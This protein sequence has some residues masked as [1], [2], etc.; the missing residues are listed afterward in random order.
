MYR[1][2]RDSF[3]GNSVYHI[4]G[5]KFF[6]QPE[7]LESYVVDEKYLG[8]GPE[9][10]PIATESSK[11]GDGEDRYSEKNEDIE[12][13][14]DDS[15]SGIEKEDLIIVD[16]DGEDDPE[17]PQNWPTYQKV[18]FASLV[19]F[20]TFSVYVA[21]AIYTPGLEEI[22]S[23][24]NVSETVAIVPLTMFVV[25][26]GIGPMFLSPITE[27]AAVG[28]NYV[29]IL[30]LFIF[31]ILQIPTALSKN[32]AS[33]SVL[34][35]IS[36]FFASPAL[37]TGGA[38][39][40]DVI[41]FPYLPVGL[42]AW[43]LGAV[44]GP[45]FGPLIG[46]VLTVKH[47][48]RWTFW[49]MA[50]LSG[51][52]L[53]IL[54]FFLPESYGKALLYRKALRLR[55]L[56]G[57]PKI[58]SEGELEIKSMNRNQLIGDILWRPFEITLIEPVVMLIN[59]YI[60]LVYSVMYLWFE[61]FPIVFQQTYGFPLVTLGASYISLVI[62]ILIGGLIY[63]VYIYQKFTVKILKGEGFVPEVFIPMTIIGSI[64]LPTG[65]FIFGWSAAKDLH[66][67]GP[68]IGAGIFGAGALIIFQTL[69]NYLSSSFYRYL[70]STFASNA[71]F[72]SVIA[73]CFPLF[74]RPLFDNLKTNRFPV[75]WGSS[76]LGF[77]SVA[78]IAIPVFF[79]IYGPQLRA[80][81][82]YA[83]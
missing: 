15:S 51:S 20:L 48:W 31:F 61:G 29:Y 12:K 42:C 30:T 44:C 69:F 76:I 63:M 39:M 28:R 59:I 40:A 16:W 36:G 68:M 45:S 46:G 34:R 72:R 17:N 56:T 22:M 58:T 43:A 24:F 33:L 19:G 27:N 81:S 5:R 60:S 11:E 70:A 71:L 54:T 83:N 78:M 38:S 37:A 13:S 3:F 21:S 23:Q 67:I 41:Q 52:A 35:L 82:R 77:I 6:R 7:E 66:W 26:Y 8:A 65:I 74:G 73:G 64:L 14:Q 9:A 62:G 75:G 10:N 32:I 4:S 47:D 57:N 25:G 2:V 79:Y 49:F 18:I 55:K 1:F 80:R 53:F 50:M